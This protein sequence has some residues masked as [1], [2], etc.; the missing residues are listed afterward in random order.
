MIDVLR[1]S[2]IRSDDDDGGIC[3]LLVAD[4]GG[5]RMSNGGRIQDQTVCL[6]STRLVSTARDGSRTPAIPYLVRYHIC[7][8][9]SSYGSYRS[10]V[11]AASI[12]RGRG[13]GKSVAA[14][15]RCPLGS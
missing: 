14:C 10:L 7:S 3:A 15:P 5:E 11:A 9:S 13:V 4:A 2:D 8:S 6:P 1:D 12:D